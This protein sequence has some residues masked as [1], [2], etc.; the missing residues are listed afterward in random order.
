MDADK[1][2]AFELANSDDED[3]V[4]D[5]G[6]VARVMTMFTDVFGGAVPPRGSDGSAR[7]EEVPG[8]DGDDTGDDTSAD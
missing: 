3:M 4:Q 6:I 2:N 5:R 8:S 1:A 7:D